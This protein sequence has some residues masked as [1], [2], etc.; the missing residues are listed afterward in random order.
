MLDL[1]PSFRR[2]NINNFEEQLPNNARGERN[3]YLFTTK[4]LFPQT[5]SNTFD[6]SLSSSG[7]IISSPLPAISETTHILP[8][9]KIHPPT[10]TQTLP[11]KHSQ[12]L[13][14][15]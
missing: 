11:F 7:E 9:I 14:S 4:L 15:L 5:P 1:E 8:Q 12:T 3:S 13:L 2:N 6:D 10:I